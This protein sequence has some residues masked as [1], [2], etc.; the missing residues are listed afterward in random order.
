MPTSTT[1]RALKRSSSAP[2][3]G[4]SRIVP[5][6]PMRRQTVM[7]DRPQPNAF[8]NGAMKLPSV[9]ACVVA[10]PV[11]SA[12]AITSRQ[13]KAHSCDGPVAS[14]MSRLLPLAGRSFTGERR[15]LFLAEVHDRGG[16]VLRA[17]GARDAAILHF[18][19]LI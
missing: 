17:R 19:M 5:M 13:F 10:K 1:L 8:C 14:V 11:P 9:T 4:V 2:I 15:L 16:V 6:L 3:R 12:A 18:E 7:S